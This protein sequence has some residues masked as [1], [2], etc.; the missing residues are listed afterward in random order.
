MT[1]KDIVWNLTPPIVVKLWHK[2]R[3]DSNEQNV[4]TKKTDKELIFEYINEVNRRKNLSLDN[5]KDLASPILGQELY[6]DL[7][8]NIISLGDPE[9]I[10]YGNYYV[11]CKYADIFC[12]IIPQGLKLQHGCW[13]EGRLPNEAYLSYNS[14]ICWGESEKIYSQQFFKSPVYAIGA[15]FFYA[16]SLLNEELFLAEKKR[17]GYNLLVF[18][19][20]SSN[21]FNI[22]YN[23]GDFIDYIKSE[24]KKFQTVRICLYWADVQKGL[25][26]IYKENGFECICA[27]HIGDLYFL[28]RLRTF[29]ELSDCTMSNDFGSHIGYSLFLNKPHNIYSQSV[30]SSELKTVSQNIIN[31]INSAKLLFSNNN[32]YIITKEQKEFVDKYWGISQIKSPNEL[33]KI[34]L[35]N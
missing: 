21:A 19:S 22:E 27:G 9:P 4:T 23:I 24:Q 17:L 3:G 7:G 11:L 34:L 14:Y 15:P 8:Q 31:D 26:K 12:N 18:P 5:I 30:S 33:A 29:I 1:L 28:N 16:N 13:F 35:G 2:I 32:D 25:D 10:L 20:H 6:N